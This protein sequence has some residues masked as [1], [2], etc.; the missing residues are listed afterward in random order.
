MGEYGQTE[1]DVGPAARVRR[2]IPDLDD[3]LVAELARVE[4]LLLTLAVWEE[5]DPDGPAVLPVPLAGRV[6]LEALNRVQ[7]QIAATQSRSHPSA[8]PLPLMFGA[9]GHYEHR[10]LRLVEIEAGDLALLSAAAMCL[11]HTLA[12]AP[13][14]ELAEAIAAGAE[15][16]GGAFTAAPSGGELVEAF[17][18]INGLLDLATTADTELLAAR[19]Q[20]AR[21]DVVLT[22]AEEDA[23]TRLADRMNMMWAGGSPLDR[24]TY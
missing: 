15:A 5:D 21:G 16:S 4:E 19:L 12:V 24:W 2:L 11:G 17:A 20:D 18:R 8:P 7:R 6:A 13:A 3:D 14:S 22:P 1:Q 9:D 10:P 23:Y